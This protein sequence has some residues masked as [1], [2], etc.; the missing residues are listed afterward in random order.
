[1]IE[2]L[3]SVGTHILAAMIGGSVGVVALLIMKAGAM[4]ERESIIR[5]ALRLLRENATGS[6]VD[7]IID[8]KHR[9]EEIGIFIDR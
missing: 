7:Q 4:S 5:H 6:T 1:M 2:V 3:K 8:L 9:A